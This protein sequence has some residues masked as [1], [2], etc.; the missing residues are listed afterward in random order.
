MIPLVKDIY[1][2]MRFLKTKMHLFVSFHDLTGFTQPYMGDLYVFN[3]HDNPY[4]LHAK[5][6]SQVWTKCIECQRKVL[7][8]LGDDVMEGMCWLGVEEYVFPIKKGDRTLGFISVSGYRQ[9]EAKA[10]HKLSR[11]VDE[12]GLVFKKYEKAY[13]S[14]LSPDKPDVRTV[15]ALI[16]PLR[17][18]FESLEEERERTYGP[19]GVEENTADFIFGR[20]LTYLQ[21]NYTKKI[22]LSEIA[23]ELHCSVSYI[24]HTFKK[25]TG[26][27]VNTYLNNLR[28]A[29]AKKMLRDTGLS[30]S[31]ISNLNGFSDSN[32]FSNSF[33]KATGLTPKA[34]RK[35]NQNGGIHEKD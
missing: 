2:Y 35:Q 8:T 26:V 22:Y 21:F 13:H 17:R 12:Y 3:L 14:L 16:Q 23:D 19:L 18:M 6:E 5:Q 1:E 30:V 28:I 10:M 9:N 34:Y 33:K 29:S 4:C 7:E 15:S 20:L 24:S 25:R 11:F 31:E 27:N 32:Y